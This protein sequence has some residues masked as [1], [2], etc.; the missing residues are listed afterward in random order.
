MINRRNFIKYLSSA[1]VINFIFPVPFSFSQ[2]KNDY[3][4]SVIELLINLI[5]PV[6]SMG[7]IKQTNIVSDFIKQV[8][9]SSK[10][11]QVVN[12]GIQWLDFN[13]SLLYQKGKFVELR[14]EEQIEILNY[15]FNSAQ[16]A[17]P[18]EPDKPWTDIRYGKLFLNNL[19]SFTMNNFYTSETGWKYVGYDGPPQYKGNPDYTKCSN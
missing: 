4:N 1:A 18:A 19:R 3:R 8:S 13:S 15:T 2:S 11:N 10:I 16:S 9:A 6:K 17:Y 7:I 12:Y 5:L 14:Q